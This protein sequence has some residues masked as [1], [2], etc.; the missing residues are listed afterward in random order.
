M[1]TKRKGVDMRENDCQK[2]KQRKL[3]AFFSSVPGAATTSRPI[4]E[5]VAL[6]VTLQLI[7]SL[8]QVSVVSTC[9]PTEDYPLAAVQRIPLSTFTSS[10][11]PVEDIQEV[12]S[13]KPNQPRNFSFPEDKNKRKFCVEWFDQFTW[14]EWHANGREGGAAFCHVCR[15]SHLRG[16]L[17]SA[18]AEATFSQTGY[19]NWKNGPKNFTKHECSE[20]HRLMVY[21]LSS[22]VRQENVH[23][24]LNIQAD[25]QRKENSSNLLTIMSSLQYLTRQGL[26]TRGHEDNASNFHQLLMLRC[27]DKPQLRE[28]LSKK[29]SWTSHSIQEEIIESMGVTVMR[30]IASQ[31]QA[32]PFY[33]ILADETSDISRKE[34]LVFCVRTV[35][36]DLVAE[37]DVL[38]L[39]TLSRC[40]AETIL[41]TIKDILLR[42]NLSLN[43][44][45][46]ACFDGAATFSGQTK[47]VGIRLQEMERRI[48]TSH[49]HMHCVN[50]AVQETVK[51][52]PLLRNFMT[53]VGDLINFIRDSP[54]RLEIVQKVATSLE[55]PQA[56]VR[57]LCPTRF[58]VK[59]RA[60]EGMDKQL[61]VLKEALFEIEHGADNRDMRSRASGFQNKIEKFEFHFG[62]VLS[63]RLFELTD[64]L[65]KQLQKKETSL[66]EGL[67]LVN[68][69]IQ[70]LSA[71]RTGDKFCE[72][73]QAAIVRAKEMGA[74]D[75]K[76]RKRQTAAPQRFQTSTPYIFTTAEEFYR[77]QYFETF[78]RVI[79]CMRERIVC[80]E[81][82]VLSAIESLLS[83][84]WNGEPL[85]QEELSVVTLHYGDDLDAYRL[86]AQL[87][88]L[89]NLRKGTP[90]NNNDQHKNVGHI[91]SCIGAC[92]VK[93]MI[94]QVVLMCKLYLLHPSTT[95]T[96]ERTFSKLR[97]LKSYL[98]ST[99]TQ[100]RLNALLMLFIY[101]NKV[102]KMDLKKLVNDFVNSGD[103]KRRNAFSLL[104]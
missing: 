24:R 46:G 32:Q 83:S 18:K 93:T 39:H 64:R 13:S 8:S 43:K 58:T 33:S 36:D 42:Y 34:Q 78:D 52:V 35:T 9:A 41:T 50:L 94:P 60:L 61:S 14:L 4:A 90:D 104:S 47:G 22:L 21:K 80:K 92:S 74:G 87:Q 55:C 31:L 23:S 28:W 62:L 91:I 67:H 63:L 5:T 77:V 65:S 89:E 54:K 75:P 38:G 49:C 40:D 6:P 1:S 48:I 56:H 15:E 17:T 37:E 68:H 3:T 96:P 103:S 88:C 79:S 29:M 95:A 51:E 25:V 99:M 30:E 85:S 11:L 84:A 20:A 16:L 69:T 72:I 102:D 101:K 45:R 76:L 98:R 44:C 82:P 59:Y 97:M 19:V 73:W 53:L 2:D 7:P 66:G 27:Q 71:L 86:S 57:P 70:E 10:D 26:A 100:H 81:V 12:F